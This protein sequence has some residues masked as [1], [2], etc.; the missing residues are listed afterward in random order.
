MWKVTLK[1]L[2]AHKLRLVLTGLAIIL[3]VAFVAGTYVLTDTIN[4][5]F[6]QLFAQTTRGVDVAVRTKA[7]F[8][9]QGNPQRAPMPATLVAAVRAVPGVAAAEGS[10]GGYAQFVGK[11]G[12][13]VTTGGAPTLGVSMSSV[14]QFQSVTTLRDGRRP[15]G[16]GEV[17]VDAG[18]ARKQGFGVGDRVKI[19]FQGPPR[20]FTVVGIVGFGEADNLAGATL[21]GFDLATAQQVLNRTGSYDQID[22]DEAN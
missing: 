4:K 15:A 2:A 12:K 21:A 19:L 5:T 16:P 7:T 6:T 18:T 9:A 3:G 10:V 13:P 20:T 22:A 1:G 14:P 11:A 8:S 17:A